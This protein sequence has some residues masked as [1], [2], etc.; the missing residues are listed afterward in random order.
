VIRVYN[1]IDRTSQQAGVTMG[2]SGKPERACISALAGTGL[3]A[4]QSAIREHLQGGR[5]R[6]WVLLDGRHARLRAQLFELGAV[7]DE[8]ITDEGQWNLYVDL[9]RHAAERLARQ[10]GS[11][12]EVIRKQLLETASAA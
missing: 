7:S 3:D 12:G 9:S 8:V 11:D 2:A 10:G 5:I 1:K 6:R 4:L